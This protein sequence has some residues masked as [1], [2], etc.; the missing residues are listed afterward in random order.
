MEEIKCVFCND[1]FQ[2]IL[3]FIS[4]IKKK[5]RNISSLTCPYYT[6]DRKYNRLDSY[7]YHLKKHFKLSENVKEINE[8]VDLSYE[9]TE[10]DF[11]PNSFHTNDIDEPLVNNDLSPSYLNLKFDLIRQIVKSYCNDSIPRNKTLEI[12]RNVANA[13]RNYLLVLKSMLVDANVCSEIL[14]FINTLCDNS[15]ID[16][17]YK[18]I[19][20][21]KKSKYFVEVQ[22]ITLHKE[23][24]ECIM[25]AGQ[26]VLKNIEYSIAILPLHEMFSILFQKTQFLAESIAYLNTLAYNNSEIVCNYMQSPA[27]REKEEKCSEPGT[28]LM[29]LFIYFDEF[30]PD[31]ALGSHA[32]MQ[33]LAGVYIKLPGIPE[34]LQ[35]KLSHI[36]V[37]ML[38]FAEDR[39]KFGNTAVFQNF[40]T[41]LNKLQAN[42]IEIKTPITFNGEN[43]TNVKIIPAIV[44]GDNLGLNAILGFSESFSSNYYC[45]LCKEHRDDIKLAS[46]ENVYMLRNPENYEQDLQD[47]DFKSSGIKENS[48]W[49]DLNNFHVTQNHCVDVMHDLL[50][51]VCH[52]VLIFIL[53]RFIEYHKFFSLQQ[54]NYRMLTFDFGP[55][56]SRNKPP[57]LNSDFHKKNKLKLS[58][59]ETLVFLKSFNLMLGDLILEC[60][61]WDLYLLLRQIVVIACESESIQKGIPE[62]FHQLVCE[63]NS[64]Y[65]K[66]TQTTLKPKFHNLFHY[67]T[68]MRK[69]GP[70]K[71]ISSMRFESVHKTL[72]NICN[73]SNNKVNILKT[74]F[75]KYQ[76]KLFDLFVNYA[77]VLDKKI[78]IGKTREVKCNELEK[79]GIYSEF[80][81]TTVSQLQY[82][83]MF[84]KPGMVVHIGEY[85]DN[86]P[87]FGL[88]HCI[89]SVDDMFSLC[90]QRLLNHGFDSHYHAFR[91]DVEEIFYSISIKDLE[92]TLKSY[93]TITKE[94][95]MYI[96]T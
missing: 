71:H 68:I 53:K 33:K 58:A 69:V 96:N 65:M 31:N 16:S 36:F 27:W 55:I 87:L 75:T 54:L 3:S 17:E 39:K 34:Y 85:E 20:E 14:T 35:S 60:D 4:H 30:E 90:V 22:F 18:L 88:I 50:E 24:Q 43:I 23:L 2:Y 92:S 42:G 83:H 73:S 89:C 48:V 7:K 91:I 8:S 15:V 62:H 13:F 26:T 59:S 40:I 67:A 66:L 45:R 70:L 5:H 79:F 11:T 93:I 1:T 12:I 64:L 21:F 46:N 78:E 38:L 41:E 9:L 51:G 57:I 76:I 86:I 74:I 77:D 32:G 82:K 63:H 49:N 6:C 61:E 56:N 72:K 25:F 95:V 84:F 29:P 52:Y 44:L 81:L 80:A 19:N 10:N 94:N 47:K 37:S 28:L